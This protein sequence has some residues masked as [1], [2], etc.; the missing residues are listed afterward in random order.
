M[1]ELNERI[2]ELNNKTVKDLR[3]TAK[4]FG[5]KGYGHMSKDEVVKLIADFFTEREANKTEE[6]KKLEADLDKY[7][8][9]HY[10]PAEEVEKVPTSEEPAKAEE[11][12]EAEIKA[13]VKSEKNTKKIKSNLK[14]IVA[15]VKV[16]LLAFTGMKIGEYSA[17]LKDGEYIVAVKNGTELKFDTNGKQ[18]NAKNPKFG[19]KIQVT[20]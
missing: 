14:K 15:T 10:V 6:Q 19:N 20:A 2:A 17:E 3:A 13:E 16:T 5:L 8:E 18:L 11:V 12:P 1:K 9:E 7:I 4:A